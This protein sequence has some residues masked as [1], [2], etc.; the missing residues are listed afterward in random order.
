MGVDLGD[1]FQILEKTLTTGWK[2]YIDT[3]SLY[4]TVKEGSYFW[5]RFE[6]LL[7][8]KGVR[9]TITSAVFSEIKRHKHSDDHSMK[10]AAA[11]LEKQLRQ[12]GK[13]GK[14]LM[15]ISGNTNESFN[16]N[17]IVA[18][19]KERCLRYSQ[20]YITNDLANAWDVYNAVV[21]SQSSTRGKKALLIFRLTDRGA[22][23]PHR[24][25][26]GLSKV[27]AAE[28]RRF[29]ELRKDGRYDDARAYLEGAAFNDAEDRFSVASQEGRLPAFSPA[30]MSEYRLPKAGDTVLGI[31]EGGK[32]EVTLLKRLARG[33]E[34]FV[35]EVDVDDESNSEYLA[36][37]YKNK[38][39]GDPRL[40][41]ET[42]DKI[43][44]IVSRR[45]GNKEAGSR[46][47]KL[48]RRVKFP[49][50]VL[51]N[52]KN[53]FLGYLMKKARG[54]SLHEFISAGAVESEFRRQFPSVTKI[55]LI[56]ICLNFLETMKALHKRKIIVGDL[57][58][59]NILVDP[60]SNYVTLIDADSYQYEDKFKCN[61]GVEAYT[62][63][64]FL[65]DPRSVFRTEQDEL[66]VIARILFETLM[67]V[68]NPYNS[69]CTTGDPIND[70]IQ[71]TFRYTFS[72]GNGER[73]NNSEAPGRDL[74]TRWGHL[75]K[76]LK[77]SF[78]NTF[79]SQGRYW[80]PEDRLAL[81]AWVRMLREYKEAIIQSHES[82]D[83]LVSNE[84]F[85]KHRAA[86]V[87][88]CTCECCGTFDSKQDANLIKDALW[89]S[90]MKDEDAYQVASHTCLDCFCRGHNLEVAKCSEC[91]ARMVARKGEQNLLCRVC[92]QQRGS[93]VT[94]SGLSSRQVPGSRGTVASVPNERDLTETCDAWTKLEVRGSTRMSP[95]LNNSS[96]AMMNRQ[97]PA[98]ATQV[99]E[100]GAEK[101]NSFLQKFMRLLTR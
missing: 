69:L 71:G 29:F 41:K 31:H 20:V 95:I 23:A 13:S 63:P 97:K 89:L 6:S 98:I 16:D 1:G 4:K 83:G 50:M 9:F 43:S 22:L 45:F 90:H 73:I 33:G 2:V 61:V 42:V 52:D 46:G 53:E 76:Q 60:Q 99:S 19:I 58:A 3:C 77:D 48:G 11:N 74:A 101:H 82:G 21:N 8:R 70:M 47:S 14:N 59:N 94:T 27:S 79:H 67:L 86:W 26:E 78:G 56:D 44:Y 91:G 25:L 24:E 18:L 65:K 12:Y 32:A 39:L 40:A 37:I 54:V 5:P 15:L 30:V 75:S 87:V 88:H 10:N 51:V 36:K 38:V 68:D 35:Y 49:L 100:K 7:S 72:L 80:G 92:R 62:S 96:A 85:P 34:G 81:D 28:V 55:D 64:E 17:A 84:I 57:N 66:F 93:R